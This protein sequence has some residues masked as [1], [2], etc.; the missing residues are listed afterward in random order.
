ME[1]R[2]NWG[3]LILETIRT[4]DEAAARI[5]GWDLPRGLIY[6]ALFAVAALNTLLA[7]MSAYISPPPGGLGASLNNPMMFWVLSVGVTVIFVHLLFWAGTMLGGTGRFGDL[8]A[9]FVWLEALRLLG[10]VII[11][12]ATLMIPA[13]ALLCL[14]AFIILSIWLLLHFVNAALRL[15]SLLQAGGLLIAS[16]FGLGLGLVLLISLIGAAN[17]GLT[18]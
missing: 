15:N 5:M 17:L 10:Q 7:A 3:E 2:V 16:F 8:L 18:S 1:A 6:E 4:P 9:L 14:L 11:L 13:L 12:V